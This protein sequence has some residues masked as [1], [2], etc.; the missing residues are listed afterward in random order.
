VGSKASGPR[1]SAEGR[2]LVLKTYRELRSFAKAGA[3]LGLSRQR[4]HQI[5]REVSGI[6]HARRVAAFYMPRIRKALADPTVLTLEAV[7]RRVGLAR[8]SVCRRLREDG[9]QRHLDEILA[10][11]R[12]RRASP[13]VHGTM[14]CYRAGCRC[15]RCR[16]ANATYLYEYRLAR[17]AEEA[18]P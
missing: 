12:E 13:P 3:V 16:W 10:E 8:K 6:G 7:G 14:A 15:R 17:K 1:L 2:R 4:V 9:G 18:T 5:V 11:L